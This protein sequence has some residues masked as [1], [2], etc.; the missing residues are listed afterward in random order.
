MTN[1]KVEL[2]KSNFLIF[3]PQPNLSSLEKTQR[4]FKVKT[5]LSFLRAPKLAPDPF[6]FG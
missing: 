4:L 3:L 5:L 1:Q 2:I 6:F